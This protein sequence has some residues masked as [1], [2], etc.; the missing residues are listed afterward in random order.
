MFK[1]LWTN[2][3]RDTIAS[4]QW[5]KRWAKRFVTVPSLI[6]SM[7]RRGALRRAGA[8]IDPQNFISKCT[9]N[10]SPMC[11]RVGRDSFVGKVTLHLHDKIVIGNNVVINDGSIFFTGGHDLKSVD[12][13][14]TTAPIIIH[15]YAWIAS[16]ALLLPGCEIG[17]GAVVGAGA[18]VRGKLPD[19]SISVGNPA[20][21]VE[22]QRTSNLSYNPIRTIA[23]IE[24]WLGNQTND[25]KK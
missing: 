12:F 14:T 15:D 23:A 16:N 1:F 11:L 10:G 19:Y 13:R 25:A 8:D 24:A 21:L 17:F 9:L 5:W 2:R 22:K 4:T 7:Y 6:G 3:R 20:R 18:V